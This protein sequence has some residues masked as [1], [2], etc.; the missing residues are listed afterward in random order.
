[1]DGVG[2]RINVHPVPAERVVSGAETVRR[3]SLVSPALLLE[4][5]FG[6]SEVPTLCLTLSSESGVST[7]NPIRMTCAF[8]YARGRSRS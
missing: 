2:K 4:P 1:M 5:N 3:T 7:E 8:E 6:K